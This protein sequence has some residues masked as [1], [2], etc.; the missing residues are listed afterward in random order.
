MKPQDITRLPYN[1]TAVN[2]Y[3]KSYLEKLIDCTF[4]TIEC[5]EIYTYLATS[6]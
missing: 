3:I 5:V 6:K 4:F 2:S 1:K